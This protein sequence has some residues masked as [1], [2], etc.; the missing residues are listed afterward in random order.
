MAM[1]AR[2]FDAGASTHPATARTLYRASVLTWRD[3]LGVIAAV[4]IATCAVIISV[5]TGEWHFVLA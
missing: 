5:T 1:D 4:M 3:G 2:A